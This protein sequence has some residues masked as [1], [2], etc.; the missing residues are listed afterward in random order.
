M[1]ISHILAA[2][3][4]V[5]SHPVLFAASY[6]K[7]D[8]SVVNPILDTNAA[9]HPYIGSNLDENVSVTNADL[10]TADLEDADLA[11]AIL[12]GVDLSNAD[13]GSADLRFALLGNGDLSGADL[14]SANLNSADLTGVSLAGADLSDADLGSAVLTGV[15]GQLGSTTN[16]SLPVAYKLHNSHIIGP[17]VDLGGADLTGIDVDGMD[18]S[19]VNLTGAT[20]SGVEGQLTNATNLTLPN[21]YI[22]VNNT[23]VGPGANLNSAVLSGA[24]LQGMDLSGVDLSVAFLDGVDLTGANL[25]GATMTFAL[26]NNSV[27]TNADLSGADLSSASLTGLKG[28]LAASVGVSLPTGYVAAGNHI[29][30]PGVNLMN[31]TLPGVT[32]T[33]LD[34]GGVNLSGADLSGAILDTI[35]LDG[36]NLGGADLSGASFPDGSLVNATLSGANLANAD[37]G[38]AIASGANFAGADLQG[39]DLEIATLGGAVFTGARYNENT[40]FASGTDPLALGMILI[41]VDTDGDGVADFVEL[42]F[43]GDPVD[44]TDAHVSVTAV[45]EREE[46][47]TAEQILDLRVGG[48][49]LQRDGANFTLNYTIEESE[50]LINWTPFPDQPGPF[51]FAP[52]DADKK[53]V[54]ITVE[55]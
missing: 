41:T 9:V 40:Q 48:V 22:I 20:L 2:G 49:M 32:L 36:A 12:T 13:L 26:L 17:G 10:S 53:F 33:G 50:D 46:K 24:N 54:H 29:I 39:A 51:V 38:N 47:F 15:S 44:G 37:L 1:R 23:I 43:G 55:E 3:I 31:A 14:A 45:E 7:N 18:L 21:G 28:Q 30:G 6:T 34:L 19:H 35:D 52:G 42:A 5:V 16:L 8:G 27:V 4:L 11:F 25:S